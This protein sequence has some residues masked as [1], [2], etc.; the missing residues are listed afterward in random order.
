[1][2][3]NFG[4]LLEAGAPMRHARAEMWRPQQSVQLQGQFE[5]N[6]THFAHL[7]S[8]HLAARHISSVQRAAPPPPAAALGAPASGEPPTEEER[9]VREK[10][11]SFEELISTERTYRDQLAVVVEKLQRPLARIIRASGQYPNDEAR[12]LHAHLM[13]LP[14][15]ALLALSDELNAALLHRASPYD[16]AAL[17]IGDVFESVADRLQ[18]AMCLWYEG[19]AG[20]DAELRRGAHSAWTTQFATAAADDAR[21]PDSSVFS[22]LIAP[23]QR[24]VRQQL[25]LQRLSKATPAGHADFDAL[26]RAEKRWISILEECNIVAG[27]SAVSRRTAEIASLLDGAPATCA[28]TAAGRKLTHEGSLTKIGN[29]TV[30]PDYF[31]LFETLS[32]TELLHTSPPD[33][34]GRFAFKRFLRV[35][36]VE[37][38]EL[39]DDVSEGS[40]GDVRKS[41]VSSAES[42]LVLR[43]VAADPNDTKLGHIYSLLGTRS[44]VTQ[45]KRSCAAALGKK[46][47]EWKLRFKG[48]VTVLGEGFAAFPVAETGTAKHC[49]MWFFRG[50]FGGLVVRA[51][52]GATRSGKLAWH[53]ALRVDGVL[54]PPVR[55]GSKISKM[56]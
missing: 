5:Q 49:F 23:T 24:L 12:V 30:R 46:G 13:P 35:L 43:F 16:D 50:R 20:A 53:E 22:L 6:Q 36:H 51:S 54:G 2:D 47:N 9:R 8:H 29:A 34:A 14:A 39:L 31:F 18:A 15:A 52:S 44:N 42:Q 38:V 4:F 19:H 10:Q 40:R 32:A 55:L 3:L 33:A 25:F 48:D 56:R 28:V 17:Q 26:K 1:M 7:L 11:K 45:W 21:C 41:F 37:D 27:A